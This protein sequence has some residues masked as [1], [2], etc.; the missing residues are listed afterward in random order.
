MIFEFREFLRGNLLLF[1]A[2]SWV[3]GAPLDG[4]TWTDV[5]GRKMDAEMVRASE[6]AVVVMLRGKEVTIPLEKLSD[7]DREFVAEWLE[8]HGDEAAG[9]DAEEDPLM[10]DG[11]LLKAG[12]AMNLFEYEYT[13]EDREIMS[14]LKS[15]PKDTGWKVAIAVPEGFDASKPQRVFVACAAVNNDQ[16]RL[17][18]NVGVFGMYAPV[19]AEAGWVCIAYDTNLGRSTHNTDLF[20]AMAKLKAE[21]P[22]FSSWEFA[23]GGFSGGAKACFDPLGYLVSKNF[24]A[25]GA[26]LAG[27]NDGTNCE[28]GK[29][30]HR[31]RTKGYREVKTFISTGETDNLVSKTHVEQVIDAVKDGGIREIR[32]EFFKGGHQ[33]HRP[34]FEEAL[35][36]FSEP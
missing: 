14:K 28:L 22:Q 30:R 13:D 12:G 11:K 26:F 21:W 20:L 1:G 10:F 3:L 34:H 18:G 2:L 32:S 35:K 33:F 4:R 15:E 7:E 31:A 27:C 23:V 29:E 8:E 36:W 6:S 16:Q 24:H 19:C 25:V 17:A 5:Q 9:G